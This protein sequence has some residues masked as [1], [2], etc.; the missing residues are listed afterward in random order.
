MGRLDNIKVLPIEKIVRSTPKESSVP[1]ETKNTGEI[2]KWIKGLLCVYLKSAGTNF[3][4]IEVRKQAFL[5]KCL[6]NRSND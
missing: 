5:H 1:R 6:K 2:P 4:T 3:I